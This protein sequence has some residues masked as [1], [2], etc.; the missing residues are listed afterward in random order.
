[1]RLSREPGARSVAVLR[2]A[3]AIAAATLAVLAAASHADASD[4]TLKGTGPGLF[5]ALKGNVNGGLLQT[6]HFAG[7]LYVSV[8]GGPS[9]QAYCVDIFA[10]ISVGDTLPQ[11]VPDYPCEVT[12]ILANGYP[13]ANRIPTRLAN[14]DDEAA[15][16]QAAVWYF[17]DG[18][19][20]S[21]PAGVAARAAQIVAAAKSKCTAAPVVPQQVVISPSAATLVV[22]GQSSQAFVATVTDTNNVPVANFPI[23]VTI[24]GFGSTQALSTTTDAKGQ[25]ST[26]ITNPTQAAGTATLTVSASYTVPVGVKFWKATKQGI[27]LAGQA[28]EGSVSGAADLKCVQSKATS[29]P[30]VTRTPTPTATSAPSPTPTSA[31]WDKSSMS[32]TG[33]CAANGQ[34]VFTVTNGGTGNMT[35]TTAWRMYV[36]GVLTQQGTIVSLNAGQ[37]TQLSFGPY[38]GQKVAIEV[39][40]RPGHPGVGVAKADV[41]CT[42][43][44]PTATPTRTATPTPT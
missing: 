25:Y 37:S 6:E 4:A 36:G 31:G 13:T 23:Q 19:V 35:G 42:P 27:V 22:P 1:M 28:T 40:Q 17:T 26:T 2:A 10:G 12:W 9:T 43:P 33:E 3:M 11:S 7:T 34:A 5:D 44:T 15:A 41:T 21:A 30:A 32:V 14:N 38:S 20:A 18:F 16:V 29:S 24:Q 8:D 39:D